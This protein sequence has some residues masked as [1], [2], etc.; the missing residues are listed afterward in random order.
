MAW[1]DCQPKNDVI[2]INTT[3]YSTSLAVTTFDAGIGFWDRRVHLPI[4][5]MNRFLSYFPVKIG[6]IIT[7]LAQKSGWQSQTNPI[8]SQLANW[9]EIS[10]SSFATN[11]YENLRRWRR[12]KQSH[13]ESQLLDW[14]SLK[15]SL[16]NQTSRVD[17]PFGRSKQTV[18]FRP[19]LCHV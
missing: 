16:V 2:P 1:L 6:K 3:I 13:S 12:E 4:V 17:V 8:Q 11:K 19:S 15:Y 9:A 10:V 14:R 5:R 7:I 18:T